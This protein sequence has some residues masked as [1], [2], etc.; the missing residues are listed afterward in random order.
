MSET[1]MKFEINKEAIQDMVATY[2]KEYSINE[3]TAAFRA[4][5]ETAVEELEQEN[6][7]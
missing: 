3:L 4:A 6:T 1:N 2:G 5:I 7:N